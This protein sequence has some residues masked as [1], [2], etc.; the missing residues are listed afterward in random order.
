[1]YKCD[2]FWQEIETNTNPSVSCSVK[3]IL[4]QWTH[5]FTV[6]INLTTFLQNYSKPALYLNQY[7]YHASI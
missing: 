4:A 1:M 2:I 7:N 5:M 6:Q 3:Q